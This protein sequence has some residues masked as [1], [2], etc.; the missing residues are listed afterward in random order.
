M[1]SVSFGKQTED[2]SFGR[3]PDASSNFVGIYPATFMEFNK[4]F[5]V[6]VLDDKLSN[7]LIKVYP[8]PVNDIL[9][10]EKSVMVNSILSLYTLFGKEVLSFE[11]NL[12]SSE[13]NFS[14]LQAG[15]YFLK[16][17]IPGKQTKTFKIIKNQ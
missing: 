10:I 15:V 12:L 1:D 11:S 9:Y 5:C 16:V 6:S 7:S 3:C 8:N 14:G 2:V 13:L 17:S 4:F